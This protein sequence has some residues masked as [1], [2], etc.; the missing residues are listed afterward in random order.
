MNH[1]QIS[2]PALVAL[3]GRLRTAREALL[4]ACRSIE[5][6]WP[7]PARFERDGIDQVD[8][9]IEEIDQWLTDPAKQATPEVDIPHCDEC[10]A[11][12]PPFAP[13]INADHLD[14]CSLHPNNV[15][16]GSGT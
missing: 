16:E 4:S 5:S 12:L 9:A 13:L 15:K 2:H 11:D 6:E 10:G 1:V 8:K 3:Q 7:G 14:W